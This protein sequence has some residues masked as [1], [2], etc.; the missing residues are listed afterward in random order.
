MV[1]RAIKVV[2]FALVWLPLQ[3]VWNAVLGWS[4][5]Q[6][7]A[8]FGIKSPTV[9][10]VYKALVE[11]GP[12]LLVAAVTFYL[13]HLWWNR[14]A[15]KKA[16]P[17]PLSLSPAARQAAG[18]ADEEFIPLREATTIAYEQLRQANSIYALASEKLGYAG[19]NET[20]AEA[21]LSWFAYCIAP[22]IPVYGKHP[23]SR[24]REEIDKAEFKRGGFVNGGNALRYHNEKEPKYTELEV[25]KPDLER[26]VEQLKS[27]R[28]EESSEGGSDQAAFETGYNRA[29]F[30][31]NNASR[32]A[33]LLR[34]TQL[35]SEGVVIRNDAARVYY[36]THLDTWSR[37][38]SAWMKEVIETLKPVSAADSEWFATLDI[39][40]PARAQVPV[41]LTGDMD[42]HIFVSA[43]NQHDFRLDRLEKLLKKYGIAA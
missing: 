10:Q 34:L 14:N 9:S 32:E 36:T 11:L 19:K 17:N 22:K 13:Y 23:P 28:I 38:V 15:S 12:S 25:C 16:E 33:A 5:D 41:R 40:P 37:R 6:I 21:I 7:A 4:D 27:A 20:R 3:L 8:W 18:T 42:I 43:Y 26:V 24:L 29:K 30:E 39:V 2:Y 1:K 35:R 31:R